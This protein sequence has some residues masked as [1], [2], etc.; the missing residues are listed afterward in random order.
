MCWSISCAAVGEDECPFALIHTTCC[1]VWPLLPQVDPKDRLSR[2]P[3]ALW[4][5]PDQFVPQVDPFL[6][7]MY[8][9]GMPEEEDDGSDD[10][11]MAAMMAKMM[12]RP[13]QGAT[14]SGCGGMKGSARSGECWPVRLTA[15]PNLC[16]CSC[17][18]R[19]H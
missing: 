3:R 15:F 4:T 2:L 13:A 7:E 8:N 18:C 1:L 10:Q 5:R 6:K 14:P 17:V 16:V 9:W 19:V 11:G 12:V